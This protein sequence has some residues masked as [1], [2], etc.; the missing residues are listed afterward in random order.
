MLSPTRDSLDG[1]R[2]VVCGGFGLAASNNGITAEIEAKY[3][4][5]NADFFALCTGANT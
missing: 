2:P 4:I 5:K 3:R 1:C